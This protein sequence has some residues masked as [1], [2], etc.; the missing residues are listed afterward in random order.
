MIAHI[1]VETSIKWPKKGDGIVGIVFADEKEHGKPLFGVVKDSSEHAAVL[2]G[3]N[4]ALGYLQ[5]FDEIHIHI[6]CSHI[7]TNFNYLPSWKSNGWLNS[8][9]EELKHAELWRE[10]DEK[11]MGKRF[12]IHKTDFGGYR[13]WLS[14]ECEK[15]GR[16]HGFIL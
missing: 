15:R 3:I 5:Q 16:K 13:K 4:N 2:C 1:I 14:S 10:I 9:G 12:E 8:R 6:S 11:L 7:A